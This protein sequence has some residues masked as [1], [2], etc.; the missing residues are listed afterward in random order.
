LCWDR[1][2][3][4]KPPLSTTYYT[5]PKFSGL[6]PPSVLWR[7]SGI[8]WID[9]VHRVT[10]QKSKGSRYFSLGRGD[11]IGPVAQPSSCPKV[12]GLRTPS[13]KLSGNKI[14]DLSPSDTEV[15]NGWSYNS[16]QSHIVMA[17]GSL[18]PRL[19]GLLLPTTAKETAT[20]QSVRCTLQCRW[21]EHS[22]APKV[23][24]FI[25]IGVTCWSVK[26]LRCRS[27]RDTEF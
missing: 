21:H 2:A 12:P 5:Y 15:K 16:N 18:S 23:S 24:G 27:I 13:E 6:F 25:L 26:K 11:Y 7:Q 1:F 20:R 22:S 9:L 3:V 10:S 4:P 17:S 8:F 14:D 19:C